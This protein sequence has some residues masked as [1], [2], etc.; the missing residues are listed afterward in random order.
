MTEAKEKTGDMSQVGQMLAAVTSHQKKLL[1]L[2]GAILMAMEGTVRAQVK[3][4]TSR[5]FAEYSVEIPPWEA[6]TIF[7]GLG[8]RTATSHGRSRLVLDLAQLKEHLRRAVE[9][10]EAFAPQAEE[11]LAAFQDIDERVGYLTDRA[12]AII[13]ADKRT[14]EL[15]EFIE[16]Y[17]YVEMTVTSL[18]GEYEMLKGKLQRKEALEAEIEN[19]KTRQGD[20]PSLED[21]RRQLEKEIEAYEVEEKALASEEA[22][23]KAWIQNLKERHKWAKS[24]EVEQAIAASKAELEQLR[25]QLG[26]KR[27]LVAKLFGGGG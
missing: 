10:M 3:E 15:R 5:V 22:R 26:E 12:R 25:V 9:D 6:G 18:I 27:G 7:S 11:T 16:K 23:L 17:R 21:R 24:A 1:L 19:L 4:I 2:Q 8:L 14:K 13:K 20:L